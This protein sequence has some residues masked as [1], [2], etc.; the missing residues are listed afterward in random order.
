MR[1]N[2]NGRIPTRQA[3]ADPTTMCI[4]AATIKNLLSAATKQ[5]TRAQK[6]DIICVYTTG[7]Q[8]A[9]IIIIIIYYIN[10]NNMKIDTLYAYIYYRLYL[11]FLF[12][13]IYK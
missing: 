12:F 2:G 9:T 3:A 7:A 1:I 10:N 11:L 4:A 6:T 8:A 13:Y 5:Y